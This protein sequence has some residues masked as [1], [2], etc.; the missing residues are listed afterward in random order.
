MKWER[1]Q[2]MLFICGFGIAL[3]FLFFLTSVESKVDRQ[4]SSV[5]KKIDPLAQTITEPLPRKEIQESPKKDICKGEE[6]GEECDSSS[7]FLGM[8]PSSPKITVE[9]TAVPEGM[10][11]RV[12]VTNLSQEAAY[13]SSQLCSIY[14]PLDE[15][16]T[17]EFEVF[18]SCDVFVYK[19]DGAFRAY[20]EEH[21]VE[22]QSNDEKELFF[23]FSESEYRV[24]GMGV[25]IGKVDEGFEIFQVYPDTPAEKLGLQRGDIIIEVNGESTYDLHVDDFIQMTTGQAGTQAEFRLHG[26]D[27]SEHPRFFTRA[28]LDL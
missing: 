16:G 22:Y 3:T 12:S 10:I 23:T 4:Q 11:L 15:H 26:D 21:F 1:Y 27:E 7:S 19:M 25:S 17:A 28:P 18:E 8:L 9:D 2:I 14:I 20:T 6:N 24:G 13:V 5:E